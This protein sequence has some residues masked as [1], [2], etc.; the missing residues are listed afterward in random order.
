MLAAV[1]L[2]AVVLLKHQAVLVAAVLEQQTL[3]QGLLVLSIQ[4]AAGAAEALLET[5]AQAALA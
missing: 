3:Q 5:A 2:E 4:A 1:E